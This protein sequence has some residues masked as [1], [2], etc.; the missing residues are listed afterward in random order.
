MADQIKRN[1]GKRST[2]GAPAP[3][4]GSKPSKRPK[5]IVQVPKIY[6][7]HILGTDLANDDKKPYTVYKIEV[8]RDVDAWLIYRRYRQF[9]ALY[10]ELKSAFGV[11]MKQCG[12]FPPKQ[13]RAAA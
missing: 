3:E 4:S 9:H 7:I 2:L 13:V 6:K 5:S 12:D 10:T 8:Q 11:E 1:S